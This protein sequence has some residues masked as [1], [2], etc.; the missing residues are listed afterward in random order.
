MARGRPSLGGSNS[1][2]LSAEGETA[3]VGDGRE[4]NNDGGGVE[5]KPRPPPHTSIN[6]ALLKLTDAASRDP[7]LGWA[8]STMH[9]ACAA[10]DT[11]TSQRASWGWEGGKPLFPPTPVPGL[12]HMYDG[13]WSNVLDFLELRQVIRLKLVS[14]EVGRRV[15][16]CLTVLSLNGLEELNHCWVGGAALKSLSKFKNAKTLHWYVGLPYTPQQTPGEEDEEKKRSVPS[17]ARDPSCWRYP[18][19]VDIFACTSEC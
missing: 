3:S 10:L 14:H 19:G 6:A 2:R 7:S 12:L 15:E 9:S 16:E 11:T 8:V 18:N 1:R 17:S 4:H 5:E 13:G